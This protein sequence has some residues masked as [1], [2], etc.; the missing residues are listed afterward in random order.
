MQEQKLTTSR[1]A[2]YRANSR[3]AWLLE[4]YLVKKAAVVNADTNPQAAKKAGVFDLRGLLSKQGYG[5][6]GG[7]SGQEPRVLEEV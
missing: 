2:V 6:A 3:N 7:T 4:D 1:T 5:S